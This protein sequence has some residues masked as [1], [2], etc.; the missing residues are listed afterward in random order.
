MSKRRRNYSAVWQDCIRGANGREHN[1]DLD[2]EYTLGCD[3]IG[4]Y[5]F[6]GER[7]FDAGRDYIE[8]AWAV[9]AW[10]TRHRVVERREDIPDIAGVSDIHPFRDRWAYTHS[11]RISADIADLEE[12]LE[13]FKEKY[14]FESDVEYV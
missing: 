14:D 9:A 3:G 4:S 7:C 11:R 12:A 2:V 1:V 5:E 8:E 13:N 10:L 6:W